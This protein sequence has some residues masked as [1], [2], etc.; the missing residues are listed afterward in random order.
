VLRDRLRVLL[1][2]GAWPDLRDFD[3][4]DERQFEAVVRRLL[5]RFALRRDAEAFALLLSLTRGRLLDL[6]TR[7]AATAPT[8]LRPAELVEG[9]VARLFRDPPAFAAPANFFAHARRSMEQLARANST[10]LHGHERPSEHR[11]RG[12]IDNPI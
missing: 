1:D 6:A 9:T 8:E 2:D 11:G 10:R 4:D 7:I 5:E 12:H 3:P